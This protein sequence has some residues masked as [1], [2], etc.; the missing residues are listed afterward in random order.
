[1]TSPN[2]DG[3]GDNSCQYHVDVGTSST[4]TERRSD[5]D[6]GILPASSSTH[7][8][9]SD[10]FGDNNWPLS[11]SPQPFFSGMQGN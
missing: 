3:D 10:V 9:H 11:D 6:A 4:L 5:S 7:F 8:C 2:G 1:M